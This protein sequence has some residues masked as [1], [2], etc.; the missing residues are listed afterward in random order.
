MQPD[1]YCCFPETKAH[2]ESQG[3]VGKKDLQV[4]LGIMAPKVSVEKVGGDLQLLVP[5]N[6]AW[7]VTLA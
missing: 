7:S 4:P 6:P 2:L 5:A 3:P 1:S